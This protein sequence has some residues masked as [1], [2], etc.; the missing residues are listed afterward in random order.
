MFLTFDVDKGGRVG[1]QNLRS[2]E[3]RTTL[4]YTLEN[5]IAAV[6]HI[7]SLKNSFSEIAILWVELEWLALLMTT[8][9][10]NS[11]EHSEDLEFHENMLLK[12][13]ELTIFLLSRHFN[14]KS[15]TQSDK[16]SK[17]TS[18]AHNKPQQCPMCL[19]VTYSKEGKNHISIQLN[20]LIL[21]YDNQLQRVT[22]TPTV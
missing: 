12:C 18:L 19:P 14:F 2:Q 6:I 3:I 17:S 5:L 8:N 13:P 20:H 4:P 15:N 16:S 7:S 9:I 1:G 11:K 21:W 22:K 10:S